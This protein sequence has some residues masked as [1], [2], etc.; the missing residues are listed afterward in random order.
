MARPAF[1]PRI[2]IGITALAWLGSAAAS[3]LH[4]AE[5][6]QYKQIHSFQAFEGSHP[7]GGVLDVGTSRLYGTTFD[8]GRNGLGTIYRLSKNGELTVLDSFRGPTWRGCGGH[9]R[10]GVIDVDGRIGTTTSDLP[11]YV[12][13]IWPSG[14][15]GRAISKMAAQRQGYS[16]TGALIIGP[17]GVYGTAE[18]G[19]EYG[20]GTV[21]STGRF[22]VKL[23]HAFNG[24]DGAQPHGSLLQASNQTM[25]GTT[26]AG[27]ANGLGTIF[28]I[29]ASLAFTS[30]HSFSTDE[31]RSPVGDL[32]EVGGDLYGACAGGGRHDAGAIFKYSA[33]GS[34]TLLHAFGSAPHDGAQPIAGLAVGPDAVTLFGT[35]SAGGRNGVG[36]VFKMTLDGD[37]KI[38]HSFCACDGDGYRP[39]APLRLAADGEIYG[40]TA[41]GGTFDDSGTVFVLHAP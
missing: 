12:C 26:Q 16:P 28:S 2:V 31:C 22:Y 14:R 19:G 40:T 23:I 9:P 21:F 4:D 5:H 35:T 7:L 34:L 6:T 17:N 13:E 41:A 20:M 30:L 39:S 11:S 18:Q 1:P 32:I 15:H 25:Y 3:P 33:D 24:A 8:G 37:L 29:D 27:G 38:V 10:G 36:T